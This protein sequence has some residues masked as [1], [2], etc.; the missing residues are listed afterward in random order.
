MRD[1]IF[2][3][4]I[5]RREIEP[6]LQ[7]RRRL[8]QNQYEH[9]RIIENKKWSRQDNFV[10]LFYLSIIFL[11]AIRTAFSRPCIE[12]HESFKFHSFLSKRIWRQQWDPIF[13]FFF[14]FRFFFPPLTYCKITLY[15]NSTS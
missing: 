14:V 4:L 2:Y 15:I 11:H 3:F 1:L 5:S 6:R 9:I 10:C 12:L 7:P 8:R 13:F